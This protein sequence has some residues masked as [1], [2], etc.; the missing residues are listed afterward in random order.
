MTITS[1]LS[2]NGEVIGITTSGIE[3]ELL[4][5]AVPIN[6]IQGSPIRKLQGLRI[7]KDFYEHAR[8]QIMLIANE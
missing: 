2:I 6:Y 8:Q 5:F 3:G 7:S 1:A 4:N